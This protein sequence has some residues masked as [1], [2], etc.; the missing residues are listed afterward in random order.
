MPPVWGLNGLIGS[1]V[2]VVVVSFSSMPYKDLSVI[3]KNHQMSPSLW[4]VFIC[5]AVE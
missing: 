5:Q 1:M 3:K 2:V 4:F